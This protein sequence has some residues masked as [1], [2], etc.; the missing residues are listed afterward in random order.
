MHCKKSVIAQCQLS[1]SEEKKMEGSGCDTLDSWAFK[2]VWLQKREK[3]G[4]KQRWDH[5]KGEEDRIDR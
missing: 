5:L 4:Y 3:W 1:C 2:A